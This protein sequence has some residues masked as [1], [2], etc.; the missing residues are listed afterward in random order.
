MVPKEN[1]AHT[2]IILNLRN[3]WFIFRRKYIYNIHIIRIRPDA[4]QSSSIFYLKLS[5]ENYEEKKNFTKQNQTG[6]L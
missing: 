2:I 5:K 1:K 6:Y 3:N 4:D